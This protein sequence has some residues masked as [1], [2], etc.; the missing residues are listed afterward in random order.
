[1]YSQRIRYKYI[2]SDSGIQMD[3]S[4]EN[5]LSRL[6]ETTR[7]NNRRMRYSLKPSTKVPQKSMFVST[8]T[9]NTGIGGGGNRHISRLLK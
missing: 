1:M 4:I 7:V 6:G 2:V 9:M 3:M 5:W 8:F